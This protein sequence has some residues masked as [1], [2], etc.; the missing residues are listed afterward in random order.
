MPK[1]ALNV[2]SD[3]CNK[4]CFNETNLLQTQL[5]YWYLWMTQPMVEICVELLQ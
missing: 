4:Q 5:L 3:D 2:C 1:K